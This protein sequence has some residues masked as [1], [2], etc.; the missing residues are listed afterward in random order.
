M[1]NFYVKH[2]GEYV[3][4][5]SDDAATL[6][7]QLPYTLNTGESMILSV[8][9]NPKVKRSDQYSVSLTEMVDRSEQG[10]CTVYPNKH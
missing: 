4:F 3:V 8:P 5:V 2:H 1:F 10:L 7:F 6:H 9:S